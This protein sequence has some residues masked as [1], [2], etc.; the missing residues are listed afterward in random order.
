MAEI[1]DP[2]QKQAGKA[3]TEWLIRLQEDPEN[4]ELQAQFADWCAEDPAHLDAWNAT[5]KTADL[6]AKAKPSGTADWQAFLDARRVGGDKGAG[7][8]QQNDA[9]TALL[10]IDYEKAVAEGKVISAQ[11]RFQKRG[12]M[13]WRGIGLGGVAVAASLVAA[14]IGPDIATHM[15]ADHVTSTGEMR[16]ITLSDN[17]TV[18]LAPESAITVQFD[19]TTR[20]VELLDGEAFFDVTP[21]PQ[22]PFRVGA[23]Q[24]TVTVLGTGFDVSEGN[25]VSMVGVEHGRVQ[26]ENAANVPAVFEVLEAGQNVRVGQDGTVIRHPSPTSQIGAWRKNQLIAQDQPLSDV[27]DQLRRYFNGTILITDEVLAAQTVT[28]VYRLDDPVSALRGMARAQ[29]ATVREITPWVLV[30]SKS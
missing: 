23:D 15:Q 8:G 6:M 27:V 4:P 12:N 2:V 22:K 17:S 7:D 16:T 9:V 20:F 13:S 5:Q 26:V 21:D 29:K 19:G 1:T 25:A 28:G 18:T 3:A 30:V 10:N 14:I 24:V 11:T